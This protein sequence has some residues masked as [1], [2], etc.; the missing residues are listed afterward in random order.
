[1]ELLFNTQNI[2]QWGGIGLIAILVFAETG[3][4]L[5]LVIPGGETLIF[6]SGLFVSTGILHI[7]IY[8][9]LLVL[10]AAGIAGDFSGYSIANQWGPKLYKKKDSWYFK[11]KYLASVEDYFIR[12]KKASILLGKFMPVIRPFIPVVAG[13]TKMQ[14]T[15]FFPLA[16]SATIVYVSFFLLGGYFVQTNM[17]K[18]LI[19]VE[20]T[21]V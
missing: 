1:M 10:L 12:H 3:L 4:L 18:M 6:S 13:I 21:G 11:K 2:I 14:K 7:N 17:R 9:F 20:K 19:Q 8:I 16:V 15:Q 5:G